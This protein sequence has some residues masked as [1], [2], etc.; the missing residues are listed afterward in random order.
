[1]FRRLQKMIRAEGEAFASALMFFTILPVPV[2]F[3]GQGSFAGSMRYFPLVGLLAASIVSP[4]YYFSMLWIQERGLAILFAM[5]A[6]TIF[7]GGLHEDGLAD[8]F[9]GLF[10]GRTRD[11]ILR[12]MKDSSSGSYGV[13]SLIYSKGLNFLLL[14][15]LPEPLVVPAFFFSEPL[16]RWLVLPIIAI[17]PYAR[18]SPD[19]KAGP[20]T[21][22]YTGKLLSL[23]LTLVISMAPI[24]SLA[25]IPALVFLPLPV[26]FSL[27][28]TYYYKRRLGGY[29]GDLL[30]A[31]QQLGILLA[32]LSIHL[33]DFS[34]W[35]TGPF[36]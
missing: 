15:G 10:G 6:S 4:V 7:T 29:T 8:T 35:G 27:A 26:L 19:S 24:L 20:I 1:M 30:G 2:T 32:L 34:R 12:I 36:F 13:L 5:I 33:F 28:M 14:W 11:D 18:T 25:G 3:V 31:V 16:S 9:D 17:L 22:G 23:I 21:T